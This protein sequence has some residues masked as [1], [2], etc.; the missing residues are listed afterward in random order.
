MSNSECSGKLWCN[1][2][3]HI[4][5]KRI[6]MCSVVDCEKLL[7]P[8]DDAFLVKG[9]IICNQCCS[10]N[11]TIECRCSMTSYVNKG[12]QY[13]SSLKFLSLASAEEAD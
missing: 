1:G 11:H 10:E 4:I 3:S 13:D 9:N 6:V 7:G 5:V 8:G 2:Y 12:L